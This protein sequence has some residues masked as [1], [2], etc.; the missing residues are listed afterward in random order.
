MP[1]WRAVRRNVA[2][3]SLTFVAVLGIVYAGACWLFWAYEP[4]FVFYDL[5]RPEIPPESAGLKDFAEV[6][7]AT[8]D[9]IRLYGWWRPPEP[10]QGA[11]VV[12]T[13]TGVTLSDY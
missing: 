1:D 2:V 4:V 8:E 13:G 6:G 5:K 11:I 7:V 9:G 10:G 12:F 3:A